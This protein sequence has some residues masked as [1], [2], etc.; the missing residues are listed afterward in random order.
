M[1]LPKLLKIIGYILTYAGVALIGFGILS[2]WWFE[3]FSKVQE[4]LSPFNVINFV[5]TAITLAPGFFLIW[6]AEKIETKAQENND[7]EGT[8]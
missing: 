8:L 4:L 1:K 6:L 2:A 7:N 3:G 5:A